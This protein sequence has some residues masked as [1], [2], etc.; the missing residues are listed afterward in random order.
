MHMLGWIVIGF[1]LGL[2]AD[3]WVLRR[4]PGGPVVASLVGIAGGL[5]GGFAGAAAGLYQGGAP[6]GW[7]C[8]AGM[9]VL[10]LGGYGLAIGR[11]RS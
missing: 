7:A 2:I 11:T 5:L 3:A 10:L 9:A 8:A 4:N 6:L 1:L